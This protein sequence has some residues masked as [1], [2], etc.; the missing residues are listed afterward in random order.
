M[1]V[2]LLWF[3][4]FFGLVLLF[5]VFCGLGLVVGS[6]FCS[7]VDVGLMLGLWVLVVGGCLVCFVGLLFF[8][9][10][11]CGVFFLWIFRFS[12]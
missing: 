2:F 9:F 7:Q 3:G 4:W 12:I 11:L 10:A 8:V 6:V 5:W 1:G